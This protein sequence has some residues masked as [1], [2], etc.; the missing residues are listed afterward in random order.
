MNK[1]E[2]SWIWRSFEELN[3]TE[4]YEILKLRSEVF[5]VEQECLYQDLD[6]LDTESNHLLGLN[7]DNIL[8][9]YLRLIPPGLKFKEPSL[10]RI[11]TSE[12]E[13]YR[14]VGLGKELIVRGIK[15]SIDLYPK[16]GNRIGA[17]ERLKI[18]YENLG[19]QALGSSYM[20]D[21]IPHIQMFFRND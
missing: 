13:S 12:I 5:I 4:L 10:S 14:G 2:P 6:G 21:G 15:K 1:Q 16:M 8:V 17:Q 18:F 3:K 20:E 7:S 11:I 9:A 19:Y